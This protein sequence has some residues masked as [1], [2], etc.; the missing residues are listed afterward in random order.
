MNIYDVYIDSDKYLML[1]TKRKSQ[2]RQLMYRP[3]GMP[4][5]SEWDP[6]DLCD[7]P[8]DDEGYVPD[9]IAGDFFSM[10][11]EM[12]LTQRARDV[13]EDWFLEYGQLLPLTYNGKYD[14][15]VMFHCTTVL[16]ALDEKRSNIM[17]TD[18]MFFPDKL[19]G[20]ELFH[21][22]GWVG[23]FCTESFKQKID[24]SGLI[25]LDFSLKYSDEPEGL[26]RLDAWRKERF[27]TTTPPHLLET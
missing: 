4:Y 10:D 8:A 14:G 24:G 7:Y 26:A 13:A 2:V 6:I 27:G 23:L 3:M 16:D 18:F 17:W 21:C 20:A 25:G 22:T 11:H 19:T 9:A 15:K 12:G 5:G 1:S